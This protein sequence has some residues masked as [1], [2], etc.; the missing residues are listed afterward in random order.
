MK[1]VSLMPRLWRR[2]ERKMRPGSLSLFVDAVTQIKQ[3]SYV[4]PTG[5]ARF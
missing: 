3:S 2:K 4:K 5:L 1:A